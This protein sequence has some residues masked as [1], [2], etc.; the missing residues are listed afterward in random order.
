MEFFILD[1]VDQKFG[2]YLKK[3]VLNVKKFEKKHKSQ[4]ISHYESDNHSSVFVQHNF[5]LPFA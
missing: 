5:N 2:M 1:V 3:K 4:M